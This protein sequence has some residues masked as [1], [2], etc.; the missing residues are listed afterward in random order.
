MGY[1]A[2]AFFKLTLPIYLC[3]YIHRLWNA[4]R[5]HTSTVIAILKA[6]MFLCGFQKNWLC[7]G[8]DNNNAIT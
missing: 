6:I 2:T 1:K 8:T 7:Q 5:W 4:V 3:Q